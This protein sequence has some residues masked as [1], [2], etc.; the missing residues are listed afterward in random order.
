MHFNQALA[1]AA[2]DQLSR[3]LANDFSVAESVAIQSTGYRYLRQV[4][5]KTTR[6]NIFEAVE[7]FRL[8][9][10]T[11]NILRRLGSDTAELHSRDY[12]FLFFAIVSE[13]DVAPI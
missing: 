13:R 3:Q 2:V 11:R 4:P 10:N 5:C 9:S 8:V 1:L 6:K 12:E 7:K